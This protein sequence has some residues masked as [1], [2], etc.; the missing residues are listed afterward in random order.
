[1]SDLFK[2]AGP[3]GEP[4]SSVLLVHGLSG[5]HYD[6]WRLGTPQ[7]FWNVDDTFWPLWLARDR[8]T[9]AIYVVGYRAPLSRLRGTAMHF[10][11]QATN[12]LA[13][14]LAEPALARGSLIFVGHSL[15]GLLVK[16]LLR[17]GDSMARHDARAASFVER[18]EKVAFLGTPHSG[19]GLA[20]W[21][22]RLRI[23]VR[24]SLATASLVRNDPNLRDLNN[25][26]RE[27]ANAR[28]TSHLILAEARPTVILGM[29]VP[30]DSADPGLANVRMWQMDTDHAGICKPIDHTAE[31]YIH[32]REFIARPV[33]RPEPPADVIVNKLLAA[34][35]ARGE[36]AR[37]AEAGI[38][39][40]TIIALA[41]RLRP[42]ETLDFEQ[43]VVEVTAAVETAVEI[44][45]KGASGSNLG[46]LVD[47]VL[48]RIA[49][50]TRTG[51]IEGAAREADQGFM[52]WERAEVER[53]ATSVRSGIALLEAGLEQDILSRDALNAA[54]KVAKIVTLEHPDDTTARFAAISEHRQ[55]F[56]ERGDQKGIN[57]DL[58]IAIEIAR[59]EVRAAQDARLCATA[60]NDLGNA[61]L[62]LGK[63]ES[64]TGRLEEAIAAYRA[65]L[66]EYNR[67]R[68]PLEWAMTQSNLGAA[69]RSLS[70]RERGTAKLEEAVAAYRMA[71]TQV[72]RDRAPLEWALIQHNLGSALRMLGMHESGTDQLKEA[73][74]AYRAAL[75]E[76][77]RERSPLDWALTQSN[78]GNALATLGAREG[79]AARFGDAV[80]AYRAALTE[81][82]RELVPLEWAMT[83]HNLGN[84][85]RELGE[86]EGGTA[87]LEEAVA[88]F[89]A[90]LAER[91]RERVPLDWAM[92]Q[93]NLGHALRTLGE[94]GSGAAR[95]EE[96]IA[97]YRSALTERTR[98][99]APHLWAITQHNLG[100]ALLELGMRESG[101]T[102]LKES[103][104]AYQA[105][106]TEYTRE[107]SPL[108]W[109]QFTTNL[110]V[111]QI[112]LAERTDD[113]QMAQTAFSQIELAL[114]TARSNGDSRI[115][116]Y[117]STQL[118]R[119]HATIERLT[120][121]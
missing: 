74:A 12:I 27:W 50:K 19:A 91:T 87:R 76:R 31:V 106:L 47:A 75:T 102:Q 63:R 80:A 13:R 15:G 93:H 16:Q 112:L 79:S 119:F 67:E 114:A 90:A 85:L 98:E 70:E 9:V 82:T 103:I 37:A 5:H 73:V 21:A 89:H 3:D 96:A 121:R 64:G 43:A 60:Q 115:V 108:D 55:R 22:D 61:L 113:I 62:A 94:Q 2:I 71:L 116:E 105:A 83:Q 104:A 59:L 35:D 99:R 33:Q 51:D 72:T 39:R 66:A 69:L 120:K 110:G 57:F 118:P 10:T 41:R 46:D 56:Y 6:T 32:L 36:I 58:L 77:T 49:V 68:E 84:A 18:V 95:L 42:D 26:Y 92:T 24:P 100:A 65:A 11:D 109:A 4:T 1:M 117:C 40:R 23:L 29:I 7:K 25:W 88:A 48:A 17:T 20:T 54:G 101:T 86:L 8:Q 14:L 30:P 53:R 52:E 44:S 107:R 111:G 78:L 81:R 28:G 38:E 34:L 97:A 45:K